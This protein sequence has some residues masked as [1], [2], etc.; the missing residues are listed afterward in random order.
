MSIL[1]SS[2]WVTLPQTSSTW[3]KY[4]DISTICSKSLAKSY[5]VTMER[6][7]ILARFGWGS[8]LQ[9]C[10][11]GWSVAENKSI[12]E[13]INNFFLPIVILDNRTSRWIS[14][15]CHSSNCSFLFLL[16]LF[17]F[18]LLCIVL[19]LPSS[20]FSW[21]SMIIAHKQHSSS[22]FIQKKIL[23]FYKSKPIL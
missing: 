12:S 7:I 13:K 15:A 10:V 21:F 19:C 6:S 20:S 4:G 5:Q 3:S 17:F 9:L 2:Y 14:R 18:L 1:C 23:W 11:L 22:Y 8:F 16:L